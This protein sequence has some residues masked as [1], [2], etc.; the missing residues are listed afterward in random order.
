MKV[1]IQI[2]NCR[3]YQFEYGELWFTGFLHNWNEFFTT[4]KNIS[5]DNNTISTT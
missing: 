5:I 3:K 4:I 2:E 1:E